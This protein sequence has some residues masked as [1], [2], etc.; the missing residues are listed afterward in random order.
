[1]F[2]IFSLLFLTSTHSSPDEKADV[3]ST[4]NKSS[5]LFSHS[6]MKN[7][8]HGHKFYSLRGTIIRFVWPFHMQTLDKK[9]LHRYIPI[10]Y[11]L[12]AM[13]MI[14]F[15]IESDKQTKK[16]FYTIHICHI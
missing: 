12:R 2:H 16:Q 10:K 4:F 7:C 15:I 11:N 9:Y 6:F 13:Q 5:F 8:I 14:K 3:Y 1:M